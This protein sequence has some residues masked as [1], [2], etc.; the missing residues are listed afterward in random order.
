MERILTIGIWL[1][2]FLAGY[3]FVSLLLVVFG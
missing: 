3:G 1:G 2:S